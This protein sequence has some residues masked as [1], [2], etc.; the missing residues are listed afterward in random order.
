MAR[1]VERQG[2]HLVHKAKEM[3]LCCGRRQGGDLGTRAH[4]F[5]DTGVVTHFSRKES[6]PQ[7]SGPTGALQSPRNHLE[8]CQ[9]CCAFEDKGF[10]NQLSL[11]LAIF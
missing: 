10:Q 7:S 9:G 11:A 6:W 5:Q 3:A 8:G 4:L 2:S 1:S